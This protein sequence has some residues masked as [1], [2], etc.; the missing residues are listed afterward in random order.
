MNARQ[1]EEV[2]NVY[3]AELVCGLG[4]KAAPE[5]IQEGG[6]HRPDVLMQ[7]SGM[8]V[9][10]EGKYADAPSAENSV[11]NDAQK[12]IDLG[13]AHISLA[14]IYPPEIRTTDSSI[15]KKTLKKTGFRFCVLSEVGQGQWHDGGVD[16][17]LGEIRRAQE[18]MSKQDVVR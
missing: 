17:I 18:N 1:R 13:V 16:D 9:V 3:L 10:I 8:R 6:K 5:T 11:L 4:I 14:V 7:Y 12:R 2:P 15:L